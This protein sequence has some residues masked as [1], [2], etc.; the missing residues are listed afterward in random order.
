M[1]L[2]KTLPS[3]HVRLLAVAAATVRPI[4]QTTVCRM[5]NLGVKPKRIK[6]Y[7]P[8]AT[9]QR[10]DMN[11]TFNRQAFSDSAYAHIDVCAP[12]QTVQ[13]PAH[14]ERLQALEAVGVTFKDVKLMDKQFEQLSSLLFQNKDLFAQEISELPCS[15]LA[16][17]KIE[18]TSDTPI[19]LRQFRQSPMLEKELQRQVD[20]LCRA[21]VVQPST[22]PFNSPAFLIKKP[23]KQFRLV[24][25]F[26][27]VNRI[28]RPM[29]FPLPPH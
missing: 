17:H 16:P 22:S 24:I 23:N 10:M 5:I 13:L 27:A 8:I 2:V 29:F 28:V 12:I 15:N 19:R 25:D 1:S 21:G 26:R 7:T 6:A 20:E 11:D 18:V 3:L 4:N 9:I 14:A